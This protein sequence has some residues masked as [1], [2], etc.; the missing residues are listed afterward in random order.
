MVNNYSFSF[1]HGSPFVFNRPC[2]RTKSRSSIACP[3]SEE[4]DRL[5]AVLMQIHTMKSGN[6]RWEYISQMFELPNRSPDDCRVRGDSD[7]F[8]S[9]T[10][11]RSQLKNTL[12]KMLIPWTNEALTNKSNNVLIFSL[13]CS[14]D[15]YDDALIMYLEHTYGSRAAIKW[16][17]IAA[18]LLNCDEIDIKRRWNAFGRRCGNCGKHGHGRNSRSCEG[19]ASVGK[20]GRKPKRKLEQVSEQAQVLVNMHKSSE[21]P[22]DRDLQESKWSLIVLSLSTPILPKTSTSASSVSSDG[23]FL[24]EFLWPADAAPKPDETSTYIH[25]FSSSKSPTSLERGDGGDGHDGQASSD[26][27]YSRQLSIDA[28]IGLLQLAQSDSLSFE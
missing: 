12:M 6:M 17:R 14:F 7:E 5:L 13:N 20:R 11:P 24:T 28:S 8:V 4:E 21:H 16:R 25:S 19:T 22:R 10:W 27:E 2:R 9:L 15:V 23:E 3:F 26:A 18:E 1:G